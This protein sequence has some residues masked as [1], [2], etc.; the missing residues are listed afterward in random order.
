[1]LDRLRR[2]VA[3]GAVPLNRSFANWAAVAD[4]S[5]VQIC[6]PEWRGVRASTYAF[7]DVVVETTDLTDAARPL[8]AELI[9]AGAATVVVQAWV[10]GTEALL[11]AASAAG[12]ATRMVFHSSMPQHGADH[13]EGEAVT[14]AFDLADDG[15]IGRVGFVK[16][17][18]AEA[19]EAMGHHAWYLANR[20]PRLPPFEREDLGDGLDVGVFQHPYWR[21]NVTTQ[22]SAVAILGGTAHI[23][24]KPDVGYLSLPIVEYGELAHDRFIGLQASVDLNLVVSLSECYPMSP[25]ES[26]AAG[27]PA[28]VSRTSALFASDPELYALTTVGE[29]DNPTAVAAAARALFD[30]RD[31]AVERAATWL[32]AADDDAAERWATF[33]D[34]D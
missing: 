31:E 34:P 27:V 32:A 15:V 4:P 25:M 3:P 7:G 21:K 8:A 6:H 17:G 10:P 22:L 2:R 19:F 12:L 23:M 28:L 29:A 30:H 26:Y 9:E 20:V 11:H 18:L 5:V 24:A 13:H 1:M 14:R 33:V 16:D